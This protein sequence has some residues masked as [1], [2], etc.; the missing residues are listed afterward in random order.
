MGVSENGLFNSTLLKHF[1]QLQI[2]SCW[3][4]K[5]PTRLVIYHNFSAINCDK[6]PM[7]AN[8]PPWSPNGYQYI[9]VF[10]EIFIHNSPS[11]FHP[12]VTIL[13]YSIIQ[14]SPWNPTLY[15]K[16]TIEFQFLSTT[17]KK[18]VEKRRFCRDAALARY[19][20]LGAAWSRKRCSDGKNCYPG[21]DNSGINSTLWL[22]CTIYMVGNYMWNIPLWCVIICDNHMYSIV[23][24]NH[25]NHYP[26]IMDII[27]IIIILFFYY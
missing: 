6:N 27:T 3:T 26:I 23:D 1:F 12:K 11:R 16:I 24:D 9:R 19:A 14:K 10:S 2:S 13:S 7:F 22:L 17:P 21:G 5:N 15:P 4:G 25:Y 8:S 18:T 20:P